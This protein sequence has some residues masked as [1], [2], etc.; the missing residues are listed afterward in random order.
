MERLFAAIDGKRTAEFLDFLAPEATFRFANA[1]PVRGR[2]AIGEAVDAFFDSIRS[3]RHQVEH[4]WHTGDAVICNGT[5]TYTRDD[6]SELTV[7]FADVFM[8]N[9]GRIA[10][11][12]IYIDIGELYSRPPMG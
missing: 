3:S 12:L 2:R 6:G 9:G 10:D 11:Y 8:M 4:I 7:P 5:V 1:P